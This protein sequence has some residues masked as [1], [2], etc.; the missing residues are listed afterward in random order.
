MNTVETYREHSQ[1]MPRAV[2]TYH[3]H[4]HNPIHHV[5]CIKIVTTY[6]VNCQVMP[7]EWLKQTAS[8]VKKIPRAP[9][10]HTTCGS[11]ISRALSKQKSST[12]VEIFSR[13][14]ETSKQ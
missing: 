1:N 12:G 11:N 9:S 5:Q 14:F 3:E 4:D 6:L 7:R 13:T 8:I 2:E 10:K